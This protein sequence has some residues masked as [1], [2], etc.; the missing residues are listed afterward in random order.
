MRRIER[1]AENLHDVTGFRRQRAQMVDMQKLREQCLDFART[2][3]SE[4]AAVLRGENAGEKRLQRAA[5]RLDAR[6][7]GFG[8]PVRHRAVSGL[9]RLPFAARVAP[10]KEILSL[11]GFSRFAECKR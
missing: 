5:Y 2:I 8:F 1:T 7:V 6:I 3:G 9:H 4:R 11:A 10:C